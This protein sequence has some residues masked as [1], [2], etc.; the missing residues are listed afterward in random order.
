MNKNKEVKNAVDDL[1]EFASFYLTLGDMHSSQLMV[2]IAEKDPEF[3]YYM[4][5]VNDTF[6]TV[7]DFLKVYGEWGVER[8][9]KEFTGNWDE[10][11]AAL[12]CSPIYESLRKQWKDDTVL[13][14][15]VEE[16]WGR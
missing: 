5:T 7:I 11:K 1:L 8:V 9:R 4:E 6:E 15:M 10:V 12:V 16:I 14:E 13:W 2:A 3:T